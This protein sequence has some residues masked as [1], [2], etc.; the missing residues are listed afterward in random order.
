LATPGESLIDVA[1]IENPSPIDAP[2]G[3][4]FPVGFFAFTVQD[5]TPGA[6]TEVVLL[7]PP[8]TT[9]DSYYKYGPTLTDQAPHWYEFSFDGATGAE[10]ASD[11]VILHFVDGQ[12]GDA[13]LSANGEVVEPGGPALAPNQ[14]PAVG[15]ITAPLHPVQ[16]GTEILAN[17]DFTDPNIWDMHTAQ[18]EWG[19]GTTTIQES[20][21][22]P[23]SASHIYTTPGVY[24]VQLTITDDD[25]GSDQSTFRYIV[26]YNPEGGFV[27]GGGWINSPAGA[28]AANP[29]LVGKAN[30]GFVSKYQKGATIPTGNTEFQFKVAS[31][32]FHSESY[33]WL[34]IAGAKAKYKGTGTIN[35]AG[36][37]GF[38]LS[39]ID[40]DA[41]GGGGTDRFR[42]KI[43]DKETEQLVYDSQLGADDDAEPITTIGGGSIVIH[44]A[45]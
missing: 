42:I 20:V 29:A 44:Q 25:G 31:L 16:V 19:D 27:T 24:T 33:E 12:R 22:S 4:D 28:Y 35:G 38:M 17:A 18:W 40:G 41:Q 43:W 36:T 3:V 37:Y 1:A 10:F 7:L 6:S 2:V 39:A 9:V 13:D 14:P 23:A 11:R 21:T 8:Q 32:N 30:F 34:V 26:V 5:I 45:K 15:P